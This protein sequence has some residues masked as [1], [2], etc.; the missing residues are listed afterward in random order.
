MENSTGNITIVLQR[1]REK[2]GMTQSEL[3]KKAGVKQSAISWIE[4]KKT[5]NPGAITL[6]KMAKT[7]KCTVD[8]LI[9]ED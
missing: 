1:I 6:Y 7:L 5:A 2:R 4:N 9:E 3:A 8:D